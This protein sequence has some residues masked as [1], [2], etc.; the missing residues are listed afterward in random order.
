MK[1]VF[2]GTSG[3]QSSVELSVSVPTMG[4]LGDNIV[5]LLPQ[6]KLRYAQEIYID[7]YCSRIVY[8]MYADIVVL[9]IQL[10]I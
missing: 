3:K 4:E 2:P 7:I 9:Y 10:F 8:Y 1:A 5:Y 6:Y